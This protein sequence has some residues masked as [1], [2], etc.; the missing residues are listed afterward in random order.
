MPEGTLDALRRQLDL[1]AQAEKLVTIPSDFYSKLSLYSQSLRRSSASGGSELTLRL[2]AAQSLLIEGMTRSLIETR[3]AKAIRQNDVA[4]LLP[5]ERYV[6]STRQAHQ[7]RL[8]AF[9]QAVSEGSPSFIE[10]ANRKESQRNVTVRFVKPVAE[11]VGLDMKRY[12]P[13]EVED[14][15]SIPSSNA[16]IL[17]SN[18]DAVEILPREDA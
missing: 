15:A 1:E 10:F 13:Y 8:A 11:M 17:I 5:E 18:G 16:D 9:V 2:A 6:C 7:R 14:V 12:G 4:S 3:T